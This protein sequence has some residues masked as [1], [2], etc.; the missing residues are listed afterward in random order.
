[1]RCRALLSAVFALFL[2]LPVAANA[3]VAQQC[4]LEHPVTDGNQTFNQCPV[5]STKNFLITQ[6]Y[7]GARLDQDVDLSFTP[8]Y[9]HQDSLCRYVDARGTTASLFI[10]FNTQAEWEAFLANAP[11]GVHTAQCCLP[12]ALL[13]GDVPAVSVVPNLPACSTG[14]QFNGIADNG[15][16][17]KLRATPNGTTAASTFTLANGYSENP[18]A[19]ITSL[20]PLERD[21]ILSQLPKGASAGT[22]YAARYSCVTTSGNT[23]S[24]QYQIIQFAMQCKNAA[25]AYTGAG[26]ASGTVSL[27]N[28]PCPNGQSGTIFKQVVRQCPSGTVTVQTLSNTCTGNCVPG[29]VGDSFTAACP[30]GQTGVI[31][32]GNFRQCP[33][34]TIVVQDISNTCT[35]NPT[36]TAPANICPTGS[37]ATCTSVNGQCQCTCSGACPTGNTDLGITTTQCPNGQS[38]IIQMHNF[39]SCT[40]TNNQCVC[41]LAATLEDNCSTGGTCTGDPLQ[42]ID[43]TSA[44]GST[45]CTPS[46]PGNECKCLCG[47]KQCTPRTVTTETRSCPSGQT[48]A[49][50]VEITKLCS[51]NQTGGAT[52]DGNGCFCTTTEVDKINTCTNNCVPSTDLG[53]SNRSCPNGEVGTVIINTKRLCTMTN[54]QCVCHNEETEVTR[55][56]EAPQCIPST[57]LGNTTEACPSGQTGSIVKN[58][59]KLCTISV[60]CS[61]GNCPPAGCNCH[62]ETTTVSNT[63]TP[64]QCTPSSDLGTQVLACP[65]PQTG[66]GI[67]VR[68]IRECSASNNQCVCVKRYT[69][70]N[71][72]CSGTATCPPST[73][74]GTETRQCPTGQTGSIVVKKVK[75]CSA[76]GVGNQCQCNCSVQEIPISNTCTSP[77]TCVPTT[78]TETQ[79]CPT[80]Q[81]GSII[82][83]I[84]RLCDCPG[85][86]EVVINVQNTCTAQCT[87]STRTENV[88]CPAGYTG[89]HTR[90]IKHVCDCPGGR[91]VVTDSNTC[92]PTQ[93]ASD[94]L[95]STKE[96]SCGGYDRKRGG[97][98]T[99]TVEKHRVCETRH[100]QCVCRNEDR[101]NGVCR[102][103]GRRD[104]W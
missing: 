84:K 27:F 70:L 95:I 66:A 99:I 74:L 59:K 92:T 1:M 32:R 38:G 89:S 100:N 10:P 34:G 5:G 12:R 48:G 49:R 81:T 39:R 3:Q 16:F 85:G 88:G 45:V 62:N 28:E 65:A 94:T 91:D 15:D 101:I 11:T 52:P 98:G 53:N 73:D 26:C 40:N 37:T 64:V 79:Q 75:T 71:V 56:C 24:T 63:C 60:G 76:S 47:P 90:T 86:R 6:G 31:T 25:W 83:T 97:Y 7:S 55:A 9:L 18:E 30:T 50:T 82:K 43:C 29:Q 78:R 61:L 58:T 19:P 4:A 2:L 17:T 41:G 20:F 44:G 77:P 46:G 57:D 72:A 22:P 87:P 33:S 103:Q 67:T 68:V 35:A 102:Y 69:V 93:C 54:N 36:C 21:D 23:T 42:S 13:V 80:G 96:K 51:S 8:M 104:R 14:W